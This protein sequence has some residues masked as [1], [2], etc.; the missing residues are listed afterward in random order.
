MLCSLSINASVNLTYG[1]S[2]FKSSYLHLIFLIF[3]DRLSNSNIKELNA[4][5]FSK[6]TSL[7]ELDLSGNDLKSFPKDLVL[8]NL[9]L[10][11][12]SDNKLTSLS[13]VQQLP[14]LE[15]IYL[16]GNPLSVSTYTYYC[17]SGMVQ[18]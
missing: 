5:V 6:L 11:D 16:E 10:L 7:T 14:N 12:L 2:E 15:D 9:K 4:A 13:F 17:K 3:Y 18:V 1:V 8:K